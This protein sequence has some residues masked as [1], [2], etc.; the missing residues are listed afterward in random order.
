MIKKFAPVLISTLNRYEHFKRCV[1][2]LSL[3]TYA[4]KTDLFIALDYPLKK[5]HWNGYKKIVS[6]VLDIKGFNKVVVV[7][8]EINYGA[9]KNIDTVRNMIFERYDRIILSEDDNEFSPNFLDYINKGLDNFE[10]DNN[11]LAVCGYN[12][13]IK[14]PSNFSANYYRYRGFS[15]WG[16]GTWK[17][18]FY[19]VQ[20][21]IDEMISFA[22]NKGHINKLNQISERHYFNLAT[23][24]LRKKEKYGD[25]TIF[26][27]NIKRDKYC[28][29]PVVSKVRNHGNDGSG[30]NCEAY[31]SQKF[32]NQKIDNTNSFV[33]LDDESKNS[34]IIN[35]LLR[36]YFRLTLKQRLLYPFV[37]GALKIC[38]FFS[39]SSTKEKISDL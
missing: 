10:N 23:S 14:M 18:K 32:L 35:P 13:P 4:E 6:Y 9:R 31:D 8:R 38:L 15:A 2:S 33:F 12:F 34:D 3:C 24:I 7:K 36:K 25:F 28:V 1:E 30:V 5:S 16:Y 29:F 11:V 27:K 39:N 19:N 21:S 37:I 17:H 26:L 22:Q 20:F